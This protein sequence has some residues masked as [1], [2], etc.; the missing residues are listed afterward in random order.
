MLL[1]VYAPVDV[2]DNLPFNHIFLVG[3]IKLIRKHP[4]VRYSDLFGIIGLMTCSVG[5]FTAGDKC[6]QPNWQYRLGGPFRGCF[7]SYC[8]QETSGPF[9]VITGIISWP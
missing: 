4:F 2:V 7:H 8:F 6:A 1:Q 9:R 3:I 5:V